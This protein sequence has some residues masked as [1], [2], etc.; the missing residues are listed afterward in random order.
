MLLWMMMKNTCGSD[1]TRYTCLSGEELKQGGRW[2]RNRLIRLIYRGSLIYQ[3]DQRASFRPSFPRRGFFQLCLDLVAFCGSY[4]I[5]SWTTE[6]IEPGDNGGTDSDAAAS[7]RLPVVRCVH[8]M[9]FT[10]IIVVSHHVRVFR[11]GSESLVLLRHLS[12][13]SSTK[14]SGRRTENGRQWKPVSVTWLRNVY[15]LLFIYLRRL[16]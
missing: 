4:V 14:P 2:R 7:A 1:V 15:L 11:F 12:G 6:S 9:W 16:F 13:S 10:S 5:K 8:S 3:A